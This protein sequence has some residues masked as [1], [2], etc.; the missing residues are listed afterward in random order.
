Q[1]LDDDDDDDDDVPLEDEIDQDVGYELP[2]GD[3][4][5]VITNGD[6][7]SLEKEWLEFITTDYFTLLNYLNKFNQDMLII[8]NPTKD[9][10][11]FKDYDQ[12]IYLTCTY[13][14]LCCYPSEYSWFYELAFSPQSSIFIHMCQRKYYNKKSRGL[15]KSIRDLFSEIIKLD[16]TFEKKIGNI[17]SELKKFRMVIRNYI[18]YFFD[19]INPDKIINRIRLKVSSKEHDLDNRREF[20][21]N[22]NGEAIIDFKWRTFGKYYYFLIWLIFMAFQICF[23]IGSLPSS[24]NTNELRTQLYKVTY[25][26]GFIQLYFEFKQFIWRPSEY[27]YSIWNLFDL[28]AYLFPTIT[29]YLWIYHNSNIPVWLISLSCLFLNI[30]FL[31]F[32]RAFE[33]FGIYFAIIFG[34]IRRIFPFLM[35]L[36]FITISFALSFHLLLIPKDLNSLL[37]PNPTDP[38]NPW[39]LSKK[40]NQISVDGS[41]NSESSI[42]IEEPDESTNLFTSFFTSLL[43]TYLFLAGDSS[44]FT[45]WSPTA[46]NAL[47]MIM[48]VLFSFLIV[49]YL[50][51][52]FIGILNM[53]IE[54]DY[55]RGSYLVQKAEILAEIELFYLLPSQRRRK[56]WF[57]DVINYEVRM[58][59]AQK[60]VKKSIDDGKWKSDNYL[61]SEYKDKVLKQLDILEN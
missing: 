23:I 28:S 18:K 35:I 48:V 19:I 4:K 17:V 36:I 26:I 49:I 60:Y 43:A 14:S 54:K 7:G 32:F 13:N 50:M 41:I 30:K 10:P 20:F 8:L 44:S 24:F 12:S 1:R 59:I 53:N 9:E 34:V 15:S 22:L 21:N 55:D 3:I 39:T 58:D 57:P 16:Q 45:K 33:Y 61:D 6:D 40:Y 31:L 47:L 5:S 2:L 37:N 11:D 42:F 25:I 38:N 51:N 29:S 56:D 27:I 52:L 46:D